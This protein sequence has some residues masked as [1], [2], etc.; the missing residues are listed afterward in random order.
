MPRWNGVVEQN[1]WTI[2]NIEMTM[3]KARNLPN[4]FLAE[5]V[6]CSVSILN[7]SPTNSVN[8]KFPQ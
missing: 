1:N 5:I 2:M 7:I 8:G 3:L 6:A 4:D